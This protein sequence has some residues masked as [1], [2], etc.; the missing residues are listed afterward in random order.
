VLAYVTGDHSQAQLGAIVGAAVGLIS[1]TITQIGRYVQANSQIKNNVE[2]KRLENEAKG[3]LMAFEHNN[4]EAVA[5]LE[6]VVRGEVRDEINRLP[7]G[8]EQTVAR[9][10]VNML[11]PSLEEEAAAQPPAASHLGPGGT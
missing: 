4:P 2:L 9:D 5:Q 8:T 3:G 6:A 11:L 1:L 10:V 7:G